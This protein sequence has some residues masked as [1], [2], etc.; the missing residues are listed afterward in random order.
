MA[1]WRFDRG[2]P[3]GSLNTDARPR[4]GPC[5]VGMNGRSRHGGG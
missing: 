1:A 3:A 2:Y 4:D 5:P